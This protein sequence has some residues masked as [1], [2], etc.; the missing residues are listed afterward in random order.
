MRIVAEE[1]N[2]THQFVLLITTRTEQGQGK[3]TIFDIE[4][5]EEA[6]THLT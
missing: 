5:K 3:R 1:E 4:M 6:N 2:P